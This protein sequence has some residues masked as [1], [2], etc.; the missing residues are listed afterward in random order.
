MKRR[1]AV[2]PVIGHLKHGHRM[3]RNYLAH[4]QGDAIN[5][6][7]AAVGYSFRLILKWI[8]KLLSIICMI[9]IFNQSAN[10]A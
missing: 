10:F 8:R 2:E 7:L 3:N 9:W 4:T 1:T 5:P 6:T